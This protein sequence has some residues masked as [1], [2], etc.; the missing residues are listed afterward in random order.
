[1]WT[2]RP[3]MPDGSCR[4]MRRLSAV[5]LLLA[6]AVPAQ[7]VTYRW[8]DGNGNVHFSDDRGKIPPRFR[9][10][11]AVVEGGPVNVVPAEPEAVSHPAAGKDDRERRRQMEAEPGRPHR[12]AKGRHDHKGHPGKRKVQ[13]GQAPTAPARRAQER[14]EEQIRKDRQAIE[15]AQ[16]PARRAQERAEE[17]IRKAREGTFAH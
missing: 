8:T 13:G 1:M 5:L 17:E 6:L 7:G 16:L 12:S 2:R 9:S 14:A 4:A 3:F 10:Q 15:D 11:A